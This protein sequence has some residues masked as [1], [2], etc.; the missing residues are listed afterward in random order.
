MDSSDGAVFPPLRFSGDRASPSVPAR[1]LQYRAT[2]GRLSRLRAGVFVE[3]AEFAAAGRRRRE[4][5]RI[6]AVVAT[7][8]G[9][10][11]LSHESAAAVWGIPRI[12]PA[13]ESVELL[14]ARGTRPRSMN[15]VVWRRTP[16]DPT[17]I[18]EV[19]GFLVTGLL[20]TLVDIACD[21]RFVNAVVALDAATGTFLRAD[22]FVVARG[23]P[24]SE[25]ERRLGR[26]G[27]RGGIRG[28]RTALEFAD[29]RAESVGESLSRAQI[30]LLGFPAPVLQHEFDRSDGGVDRVD[31]DWPD[32]GLFGEFDGDLKYLDPR[33][34][35]GRTAEQVVLDEK[36][37]DQ[38]IAR[39]HRRH[40]VHWDWRTAT[41]PRE[42]AA[43]LEDAGLPRRAQRRGT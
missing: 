25:V 13:P 21:R 5:A 18:V 26:L 40:G 8:R 17:E 37:R 35:G 23:V 33:Y 3:P 27:R 30:H 4:L 31:F 16:F 24:P 42:L 43:A 14:D 39:R 1:T 32:H 28:A 22:G 34:R 7:R 6:A 2:T 9:R 38:R 29:A 36:K 11:V 20:Q 10:V 19:N 41:R 12:G 15:G